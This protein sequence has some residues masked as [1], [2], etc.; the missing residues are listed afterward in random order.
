MGML[1]GFLPCGMTLI[2]LSY[3]LILAGPIDGFNFM[4]LFG[5]G[6]LPVMLGSRRCS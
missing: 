1:N 6:T 2:A 4:L 5:V 3:C